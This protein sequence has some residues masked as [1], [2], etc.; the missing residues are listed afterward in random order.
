MNT[1]PADT[2][3]S[4]LDLDDLVAT[5][6]GRATDPRVREHLASC[7]HCR[8]EANRWDLVAQAVRGLTAATSAAAR[9]DRPWYLRRHVLT[10][11]GR[12]TMLA[13][14][15][16]AALVLLG[17]VGYRASSFIHI[18]FGSGGTNANTLLTAVSGCTALEQASGTLE[19]VNGSSLLIE[20]A[21]GQPVTVTTTAATRVAEV[22]PS[23]ALLGDI[24]DG[25]AVTVF[26]PSSDGT[27]AAVSVDVADL[28]QQHPQPP[29]GMVV[30]QG[31][32]SDAS[33]AG[34]TVVAAD[35]ARVAVAISS[36]TIVG[37][38]NV[39]LS[40]LPAGATTFA[41]GFAGPDGTLSARA[42]MAILRFPQ[43]DGQL[44]VHAHLH[45]RNCSPASIDNALAFG[46]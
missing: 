6:S 19:Q 42:V 46:G 29:P 45:V 2:R 13:A 14:S 23:G 41:L 7:E 35:R 32:V 20:T 34:F 1:G 22:G 15:A 10:G 44:H 21:A 39:S 18:T 4:H 43:G 12:R 24:T 16:A 8:A 5:A 28:A 33:T 9:P 36:D 25:A 26:G 11:T 17:G 40:Q 30:V 27:I 31:T 3:S 37:V 38:P